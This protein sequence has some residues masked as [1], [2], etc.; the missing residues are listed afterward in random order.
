MTGSPLKKFILTPALLS[1]AVFATLTLPLAVFG[2][3]PVT[4]QLQQ[5]PVFQGQL[6][7]VATPYLG[8]ATV[9]SLGA[10]FAN[11]AVTGWR[12][13]TRKSSQVEA[14]LSDLEQ[15]LKEKEAQLETLKLSKSRLEAA[16][17]NAFVDEEVPLEQLLN[18]STASFG[19]S[20][21]VKPQVITTQSVEA[22][23]AQAIIPPQ[24]TVP[25]TEAKSD[26][27]Q[28]SLGDA[29]GKA[30]IDL[31]NQVT[32]LTHSQVEEL[33]TQL[34]QVMAQMASVQAA[35]SA[36]QS[37]VTSEAQLPASS[38]QRQAVQSWSVKET[39]F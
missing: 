19:T 4:I 9:L 8:L 27:T 3:K 35:L 17:L 16:G 23:E 14:K 30:S 5:E 34:Q 33:H 12:M 2:S 21:V 28:S 10:G 18:K 1:A 11:V 6:R 22:V 36:T 31:P 7:D 29:Q 20:E 15:N 38:T 24:V 13:S 32:E 26:C 25:A 37:T 39:A